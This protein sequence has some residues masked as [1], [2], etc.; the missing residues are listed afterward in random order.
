MAKQG[1]KSQLIKTF[2][3]G[4]E[5]KFNIRKKGNVFGEITRPRRNQE[6]QE[7]YK[8]RT[9]VSSLL[10]QSLKMEFVQVQFW[11]T[12]ENYNEKKLL[13]D[14]V[15]LGLSY[16]MDNVY[17]SLEVI[18]KEGEKNLKRSI[19]IP[20]GAWQS[21]VVQ[22]AV[23]DELMPRPCNKRKADNDTEA[24]PIKLF[25]RVVKKED[26][27]RE[28]GNW[29]N[30]PK[31][32]FIKEMLNDGKKDNLT[33]SQMNFSKPTVKDVILYVMAFLIHREILE[34]ISD[35][36]EACDIQDPSQDQHNCLTPMEEH[37][38]AS[39]EPALVKVMENSSEV[40]RCVIKLTTFFKLPSI[41]DTKNLQENINQE[42]LKSSIAWPNEH[43]QAIND[44]L[45]E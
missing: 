40:K 6:T 37:M 42:T 25:K 36:C 27:C 34:D 3:L 12:Q 1:T 14:N 39:F 24:K 19:N 38:F 43:Q 18:N 7:K 32:T 8:A 23:I 41:K 4:E 33:M 9:Y 13:T 35:V 20:E 21:L 15:L 17:I 44:I 22:A 29:K 10:W 28:I 31:R 2:D 16:F 11:L 30:I 26:G 45:S 5:L